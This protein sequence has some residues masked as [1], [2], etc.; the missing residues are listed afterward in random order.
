MTWMDCLQFRTVSYQIFTGNWKCFIKIL[1]MEEEVFQTRADLTALSNAV[2]SVRAQIKKIIV[3]QDEMVRLIIAAILADGHVLI[4]GVPGV[5]KTLTAK[6]V[7]RS[8][9]V[10]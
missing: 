1:K 10:Q 3:G 5:A 9:A 7:S 4:E 8:L 2:Q 6:L